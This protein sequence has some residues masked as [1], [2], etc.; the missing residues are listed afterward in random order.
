MNTLLIVNGHPDPRPERFCAGLAAA[1]QEG[2]EAGGWQV[3]R[4]DIGACSQSTLEALR[5]GFGDGAKAMLD[6]VAWADRLALVYPLWFG[7]PPQGLRLL[8]AHLDYEVCVPAGGRKAHVI[9]TMDM[10]AFAYRSLLRP[11]EKERPLMLDVPGI[12]AE[13]PV[14]IGCVSSIA[15]TQ[16]QRHL[17]VMRDYGRCTAL[18]SN[19]VPARYGSFASIIDRTVSQWWSAL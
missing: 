14:L 15:A 18:G 9:V 4:L 1:Y 11:G 8:F 3:R 16:R 13:E 6:D 19:S 7:L 12:I 10:P 17:A 5:H 2:A